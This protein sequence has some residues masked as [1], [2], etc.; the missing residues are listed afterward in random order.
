MSKTQGGLG[1]VGVALVIGF[2]LPWFDLGGVFAMSGFDIVVDGEGMGFF[3]R[4]LIA[5]VPV[6]GAALAVGGLAT[7]REAS[8]VA[9]T[10][11]GGI[12]GYTAIRVGYTFIKVTGAGL[13]LVHAADASS[14]AM[15]LA[16]RSKS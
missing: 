12:L 2:F 15:G 14:L 6:C 11:G 13:W 16:H 7:A 9:I 4:I 3:T 8:T 1:V 5:L 10:V